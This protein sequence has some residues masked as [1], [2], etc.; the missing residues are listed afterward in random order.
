VF[1]QSLFVLTKLLGVCPLGVLLVFGCFLFLLV[2]SGVVSLKFFHHPTFFLFP[3]WAAGGTL[4][5]F[6]L[7][8]F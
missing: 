2:G 5:F 8:F 4:V 1:L 6:H 3:G 7:G